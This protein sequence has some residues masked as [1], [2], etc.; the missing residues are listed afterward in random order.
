[1]V[2]K[3]RIISTTVCESVHLGHR[4]ENCFRTICQRTGLGYAFLGPLDPCSNTAIS[5][6][7][8]W[9]RVRQFYCVK[10]FPGQGIITL[11]LGDLREA[12]PSIVIEL[13][14]LLFFVATPFCNLTLS[15]RFL[16]TPPLFDQ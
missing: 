8:L 3:P 16:A 15:F 12:A 5:D 1:M 14:S 10:E 7:Q 11:L 4:I 6:L 2:V 9:V 13:T